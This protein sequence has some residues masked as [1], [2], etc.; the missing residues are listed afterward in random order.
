V[1]IVHNLLVCARKDST[2]IKVLTDGIVVLGKKSAS[3]TWGPEEESLPNVKDDQAKGNLP[4]TG[5]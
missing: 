5:C 3:L 1:E 2:I 4:E